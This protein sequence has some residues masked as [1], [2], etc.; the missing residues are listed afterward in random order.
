MNELKICLALFK[1]N[2]KIKLYT[3]LYYKGT[4]ERKKKSIKINIEIR[5]RME[6]D[7]KEDVQ[8]IWRSGRILWEC[9]LK[10]KQAAFEGRAK[11]LHFSIKYLSMLVHV[12]LKICN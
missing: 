7:G 10:K 9:V 4:K 6:L 5:F 2:Y 11:K 3:S 1:I 12:Y 8:I